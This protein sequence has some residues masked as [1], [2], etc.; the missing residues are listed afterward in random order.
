MGFGWNSKWKSSGKNRFGRRRQRVVLRTHVRHRRRR[1][2]YLAF[3]LV[4]V[5]LSGVIGFGKVEGAMK[6][7]ENRLNQIRVEHVSAE[8]VPARLQQPV[9][10]MLKP[11][12]GEGLFSLP[13]ARIE[14]E[15]AGRFPYTRRV[16]VFRDWFSKT[17]RAELE[18]RE[19]V[20]QLVP[21]ESL[22]FLD[23]G[24]R[25]FA[26]PPGLYAEMP[27]IEPP[28]LLD[29]HL[30]R[31]A[32]FL[33]E[34]KSSKNSLPA[35]LEKIRSENGSDPAQWVLFLSGGAQLLWGDLEHTADKSAR[36]RQVFQDASGRF[37]GVAQAN[38]KY[39]QSGKILV[40][41]RQP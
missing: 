21:R 40:Q 1:N 31:L 28:G 16:R 9:L 7:L 33:T 30:E 3:F 26:A 36:L 19:A 8:N 4:G 2:L 22:R 38:L 23:S 25:V 18:L 13:V 10:S 27:L 24:G 12:R 34:L 17:L 5:S 35:P 29:A 32:R 14:S 37:A 20:A 11:Y 41:P 15:I 39:F 6:A